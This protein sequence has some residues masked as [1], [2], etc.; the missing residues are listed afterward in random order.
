MGLFPYDELS[1]EADL[2]EMEEP[3]GGTVARSRVAETKEGTA[4]PLGRVMTVLIFR[5]S[6]LFVIL[7]I[8]CDLEKQEQKK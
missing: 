2:S 7:E 4:A 8:I 5:A 1:L 3:G 6:S